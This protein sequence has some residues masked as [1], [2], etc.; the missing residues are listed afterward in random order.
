MLN[1]ILTCTST[2]PSNAKT[3]PKQI[4][5]TVTEERIANHRCL[6]LQ[7]SSYD[8]ETRSKEDG[9]F[10]AGHDSVATSHMTVTFM[11]LAVSDR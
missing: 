1:S 4:D 11:S 9:T 6:M 10:S 8:T 7:A 2:V 3:I 5:E